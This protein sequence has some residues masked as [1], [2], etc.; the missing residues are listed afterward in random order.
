VAR[1]KAVDPVTKQLV[2]GALRA[3]QAEMEALIERTAMSPFIREKKDFFSGVFD[4]QGH[5]IIGTNIPVF[6]DLIRPLLERFPVESMAEGDVYWY[7]DCYGSYGGVSHSPDQVY[8]APIFVEGHLVGFIQSWAHFSDIGGMRPGSLSPDATEIFQEGTIVPPVRLFA[9]GV[10]NEDAFRIF[11][12]NS[13]YPEMVLGDTRACVAAVRMGE[14]RLKEMFAAHGRLPILAVFAD[15][16]DETERTVRRRLTELFPKGRYRFTDLVDTDGHGNGPFRICIELHS[17][18]SSFRI[19]ATDSDDQSPGAINYLMHPDVPCMVFGIY[20]LANEP[21]LL[22][23]QGAVRAFERVDLRE[24]SI[25]RPR[26]PAALG[27]RG[28]TLVRVISACLGL[29]GQATRGSSVAASNVYALYYLRGKTDAGAPF[30]LTDGVAVGNG[31]RPHADGIDAVYFVAQ[32]NYPAEFLDSSYPVRLLR[33]E[34]HC[35]S[36]GPGRWRG[37]AGVVREFELLAPSA[38]LSN[39]IDA[40][41]HP[42]WG[43]SGG[44]MGGTGRCVVNP[45]R[46]DERVLSPIADGTMLKRGDVFRMETGGGGGWGHPFDREI[47]Q[48][49]SDV[50]GG[51]VS[52]QSAHDDYGVVLT[53]PELSVDAKATAARRKSARPV[54]ALFHRHQYSDAFD[55]EPTSAQRPH[56]SRKTA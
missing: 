16:L 32:E 41:D 22:L 27:Q 25:L 24:G 50:L 5:L 48:V 47:E 4:A 19:D 9:K 36:G 34:I 30:L 1:A 52:V 37:G 40:N 53:G 21:Q 11:Q 31:A 3:L 35:D 2:K 44:K 28:V 29:I 43:I 33:Y 20:L 23:N 8:V 13:R 15:L 6:G 38:M 54:G 7:N 49:R 39:R 46:S 10:F 45:G 14:K 56:R 42:P 55:V 18:G 51:F 17:T 12:R 26:F